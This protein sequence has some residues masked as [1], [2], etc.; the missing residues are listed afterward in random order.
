M[1]NQIESLKQE[2]EQL[3][4]I[5]LKLIIHGILLAAIL[6]FVLVVLWVHQWFL[7]HYRQLD[8]PAGRTEKVE[9]ITWSVVSGSSAHNLAHKSKC[10]H[11]ES[12]RCLTRR[13]TLG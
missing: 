11:S 10:N 5:A 4:V 12:C 3:C 9:M 13:K 1:P 7:R 8:E 2:V 6:L